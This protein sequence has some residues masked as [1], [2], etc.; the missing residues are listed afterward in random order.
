[1]RSFFT[2]GRLLFVVLFLVSGLAKL[3][4]M[5]A[6][7][8]TI[9]AK[10]KLPELL[11]PYLTQLE[12]ASSMTWPTLAALAAGLIEVLCAIMIAFNLGARWFAMILIVFVAV[13]T[14]YFHDFWNVAGAERTANLVHTLKNLL[15]IGGLFMIVAW[16]DQMPAPVVDNNPYGD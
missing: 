5:S 10:V 8:Q 14:F 15:L 1:M 6:T 2:L 12:A 16:R 7:A 9:S 4:D 11:T 3:S 13:A